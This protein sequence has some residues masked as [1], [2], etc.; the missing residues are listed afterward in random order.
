MEI[1][2]P[3]SEKVTHHAGVGPIVRHL[4]FFDG[5]LKDLTG[6]VEL[7]TVL[8]QGQGGVVLVPSCMDLRVG[9][10]VAGQSNVFVFF[11][12]EGLFSRQVGRNCSQ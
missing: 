5:E 6:L 10:G 12:V 8:L 1:L 9:F 11:N 4:H 7:V 3:L 2:S